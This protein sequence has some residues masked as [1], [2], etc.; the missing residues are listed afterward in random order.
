MEIAVADERAWLLKE[1]LSMD[2]A[3][4][5]AWS[6]KVDAFGTMARFTGLLQR[7]KDDEFQLVYKEHRYEPFWHVVCSARYVYERNRQYELSIAGPEVGRVTINEVDF[8]VKDGVIKLSGLEHCR[9]EF[10]EDITIEGITGEHR[11]DLAGY[12]K[13]EKVEI[14]E[15]ELDEFAPAGVIVVPPQAKASA[16]V[17]QILSGMVKSVEADTIIEDRVSVE[18]IDLYYRPVYAFQ[19][20]WLAKD[21]EAVMEYDGLTGELRAGG[22]IFRQYV[23]KVL[24]PDFLFDVGAD[25]VELLVPGGGIA[26]KLARKGLQAAR[27]KKK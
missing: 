23:G 3:E 17:H 1:Q 21:K 13:Y 2:H 27:G 20:R 10:D 24:D 25:T 11:P 18:T 19:Y 22:Q 14:P 6:K 16:I 8:I 4:G 9:E 15:D 26:V 7:P 5:R 12:F